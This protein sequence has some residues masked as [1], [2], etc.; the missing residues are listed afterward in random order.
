[1]FN[2]LKR[3]RQDVRLMVE[4]VEVEFNHRTR[5]ALLYCADPDVSREVLSALEEHLKRKGYFLAAF[6][7][8]PGMTA[9]PRERE[10]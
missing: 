2:F 7:A 5:T 8:S 4:G 10:E 6:V 1:M 3:P 9:P